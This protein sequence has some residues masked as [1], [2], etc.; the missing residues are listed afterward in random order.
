MSDKL[1]IIHNGRFAYELIVD[2]ENIAFQ[3]F[4]A[5]L[6]FKKHYTSLGYKVIESGDG[7]SNYRENK[8]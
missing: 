1:C 2:N 3:G 6:Y 4:S 5:A 7:S 8:V